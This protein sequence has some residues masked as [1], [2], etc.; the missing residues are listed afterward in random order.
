[1]TEVGGDSTS[2]LGDPRRAPE[3][4]AWAASVAVITF[5]AYGLFVGVA[6][7]VATDYPYFLCFVK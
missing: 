6:F 3:K 4:A 5:F 7:W 2:G 1:M